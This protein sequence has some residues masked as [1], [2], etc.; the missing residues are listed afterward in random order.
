LENE[1]KVLAHIKKM[2]TEALNKYP[3]TLQED[4]KI[5]AEDDANPTLSFN[6]RNCVLFR[7][8]EKEILHFYL[9]FSDFLT[10]LLGMK[11][12]E[13]KKECQKLPQQF[14]SARDYIH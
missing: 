1:A 5:L 14:D 10:T 8:G 9:E 11:F 3:Q 2:C 4:I 6:Q 13:A 12:K 7:Q